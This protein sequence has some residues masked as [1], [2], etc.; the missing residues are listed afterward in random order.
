MV[1]AATRVVFEHLN[2]VTHIVAFSLFVQRKEKPGIAFPLH[3]CEEKM[4]DFRVSFLKKPS[5]S[6]H[7]NI[8]FPACSSLTLSQEKEQTDRKEKKR[9]EYSA[10]IGKVIFSQ[11]QRNNING[12]ENGKEEMFR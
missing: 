6:F 3:P 9:E 4:A 11:E 2:A 12:R 1:D 10:W 5:I 7:P 8:P